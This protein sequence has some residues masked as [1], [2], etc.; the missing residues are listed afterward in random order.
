MVHAVQVEEGLHQVRREQLSCGRTTDT[1]D[2]KGHWT[3]ALLS[4]KNKTNISSSLRKTN[5]ICHESLL[6]RYL[7]SPS[8]LRRRYLWSPS[9][10]VL[11]YYTVLDRSFISKC[12]GERVYVCVPPSSTSRVV[13]QR[14]RYKWLILKMVFL[15]SCRFKLA[16]TI[17]VLQS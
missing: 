13:P 8:L 3:S 17:N 12:L 15:K 7:W 1:Y 9:L 4:Q 6:R 10:S 11:W 5:M 14:Q 16:C 2:T